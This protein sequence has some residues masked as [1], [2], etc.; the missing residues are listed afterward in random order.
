MTGGSFDARGGMTAERQAEVAK[1]L[2]MDAIPKPRYDD[3]PNVRDAAWATEKWNFLKAL[4]FEDPVASAAFMGYMEATGI[5]IDQSIDPRQF[6]RG[7]TQAAK[8]DMSEPI[9]VNDKITAATGITSTPCEANWYG[10]FAG[11]IKWIFD[12]SGARAMSPVIIS[13]TTGIRRWGRWLGKYLFAIYKLD[14]TPA[15]GKTEMDMVANVGILH[16]QLERQE[17]RRLPIA[18]RSEIPGIDAPASEDAHPT[19]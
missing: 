16:P 8:L 17:N 2:G 5:P 9:P 10:W 15:Y 7:W 6:K 3:L 11:Q 13:R 1:E 14:R 12:E 4:A 19:I 18:G